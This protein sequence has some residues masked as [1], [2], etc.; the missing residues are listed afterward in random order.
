MNWRLKL[1][2]FLSE[3]SVTVRYELKMSPPESKNKTIR[4][5]RY[6]YTVESDVPVRKT[7]NWRF[8]FK[9]CR[10]APTSAEWK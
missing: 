1:V 2:P 8:E 9:I 5:M 6:H 4:L 7:Q 3:V 10:L